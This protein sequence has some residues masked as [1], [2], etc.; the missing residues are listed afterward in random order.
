[1]QAPCTV[2]GRISE[3]QSEG[4]SGEYLDSLRS[5]LSSAPPLAG[6]PSFSSAGS[7]IVVVRSRAAENRCVSRLPVLR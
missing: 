1:M 3:G 4:K 7:R 5:H 6:L 2:R